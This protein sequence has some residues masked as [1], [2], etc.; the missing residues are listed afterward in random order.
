MN[1]KELIKEA[2]Q[3]SG[4]SQKDAQRIIDSTLSVIS[5]HLRN[6]EEVIIPDFGKLS[7]KNVP[8]RTGTNPQTKEKITIAAHSKVVFKPYS[9]ITLYSTKYQ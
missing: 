1:K 8:E 2:A 3:K 5:D 9:L 6:G 7:V 4:L